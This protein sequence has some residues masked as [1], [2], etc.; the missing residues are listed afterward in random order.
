MSTAMIA[1]EIIEI[2][3]GMPL[4]GHNPRKYTANNQPNTPNQKSSQLQCPL[5]QRSNASFVAVANS[6]R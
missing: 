6:P 2:C 3:D 1:V 5:V 4:Y